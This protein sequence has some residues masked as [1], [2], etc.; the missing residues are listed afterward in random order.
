MITYRR[1]RL[2]LKCPVFWAGNCNQRDN[3]T[4]EVI[5]NHFAIYSEDT[6]QCLEKFE[7]NCKLDEPGNVDSVRLLLEELTVPY[8]TSRRYYATVGFAHILFGSVCT[9]GRRVSRKDD[10]IIIDNEHIVNVKILF[11]VEL[12]NRYSALAFNVNDYNRIEI[13]KFKLQLNLSTSIE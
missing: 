3:V 4:F 5:D 10:R 8:A 2:D 6:Q 1:A 11:S 12:Y 9:G 13:E 7:W